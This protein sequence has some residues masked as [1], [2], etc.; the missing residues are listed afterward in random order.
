MRGTSPSPK[1]LQALIFN[2]CWMRA[3]QNAL[4]LGRPDRNPGDIPLMRPDARVGEIGYTHRL[5]DD[6]LNP[7]LIATLVFKPQLWHHIRCI[8]KGKDLVPL[9]PQII[10]NN[11]YRPIHQLPC[12]YPMQRIIGL[13][14]RDDALMS[15]GIGILSP[16]FPVLLTLYT[17]SSLASKVMT[18]VPPYCHTSSIMGSISL[19][20]LQE[21]LSGS[22]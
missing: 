14:G 13:L 8:R 19:P 21:T 11:G 1:R 20:C 12:R 4:S 18:K 22:P 6:N 17:L 3:V 9:L 7:A 2:L 10:H 15:F 5:V 16:F